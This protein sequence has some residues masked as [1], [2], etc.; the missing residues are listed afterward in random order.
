MKEINDQEWNLM[1]NQILED[2]IHNPM[3]MNEFSGYHYKMI[4]MKNIV[5]M[6]RMMHEDH[7]CSN[8]N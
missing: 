1:M 2:L 4:L 8:V 7:Y 5:M 6:K 3:M